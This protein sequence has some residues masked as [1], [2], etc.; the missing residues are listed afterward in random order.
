VPGSH[1]PALAELLDVRHP[2]AHLRAHVEAVL[3]RESPLLDRGH[4]VEHPQRDQILPA[5][6]EL[7]AQAEQVGGELA[8][9]VADLRAACRVDRPDAGAQQRLDGGIR[10]PARARVVT[11][12]DEGRRARVDRL[13][14]REALRD[15]EVFGAVVQREAAVRDRHVFTEVGIRCHSAQLPLPRV[16]VGVDEP[17]HDDRAARVDHDR[18]LADLIRKPRADGLDGAAPQQEVAPHHS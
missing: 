4:D 9:V 12:V 18:V 6:E 13:S 14:R 5:G 11:V 17:R 10:M 16:E 3:V 1:Q 8:L 15:R 7:L 2:E